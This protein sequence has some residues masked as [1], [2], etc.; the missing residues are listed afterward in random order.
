MFNFR[1]KL[2]SVA[3]RAVQLLFA[4]LT[5]VLGCVATD[6][7][8][9]NLAPLAIVSGIFS[10]L[11][12]VSTL[13]PLTLAFLS[14]AVVL[15]AEIWVSIWWLIA[16]AGSAS[17]FGNLSCGRSVEVHFLSYHWSSTGCKAGKAVIAFSVLGWVLSLVTVALVGLYAVHPIVSTKGSLLGRPHFLLGAIFP[18]GSTTLTSDVERGVAVDSA[19][20]VKTADIGTSDPDLGHL[21]VADEPRHHDEVADPV[22]TNDADVAAPASGRL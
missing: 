5:F 14:P 22:L 15:G 7:T 4:F 6:K 20:E 3:I 9:S 21:A 17:D 1:S 12:Y 16:M 10:M 8:S 11:F 13:V 2:V 19:D 18:S